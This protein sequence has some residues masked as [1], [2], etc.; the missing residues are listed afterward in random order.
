MSPRTVDG[1]TVFEA[2]DYG[3]AIPP[4]F[5]P[6]IQY[7]VHKRLQLQWSPKY[8]HSVYVQ[9]TQLVLDGFTTEVTGQ[10]IEWL[11]RAY[12]VS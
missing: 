10:N 11:F 3:E 2:G 8:M 5:Y 4:G 7:P 12:K 9:P 6:E 1:T